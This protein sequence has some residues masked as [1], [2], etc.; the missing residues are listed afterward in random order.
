M[1]IRL[2]GPVEIT[3]DDHKP[4]RLERSAQRGLLAAL[5]LQPGRLVSADTLIAALWDGDPPEKAQETLAHYARAVRAALLRAGAA[6]DVLTNR[7]LTGYEL[8]VP[9]DDVDYHRFTALVRNATRESS[10]AAAVDLYTRAIALWRGDALADVGTDW[11]ERSS[12]RM[13]QELT[14][15]SCALFRGQMAVG[16]HAA[17]AAGVTGLLAQVTPTDE[18][19]TIGLEALAR[20][21]RHSDIDAFLNDAAARMW[22]LAAARPGESVH[23]LAARLVTEPPSVPRPPEE[24]HGEHKSDDSNNAQVRQTA[25]NCGT[26][27]FAGRDQYVSFPWRH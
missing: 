9:P 10:A 23:R 2:L 17:A 24:S 25:V 19:I 8:H 12:H 3:N 18:I 13:R 26:V 14:D 20:A 1:E 27:H 7:R 15:A 22:R 16:A 6:P 21:G 11:A 5:A 4:V